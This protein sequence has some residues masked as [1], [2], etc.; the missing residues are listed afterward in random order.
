MLNFNFQ[1]TDFNLDS[2]SA[3][4]KGRFY[5]IFQLLE[6]VWQNSRMQIEST[7]NIKKLSTIHP[8]IHG[9]GYHTVEHTVS[10]VN[11][12]YKLGIKLHQLYPLEYPAIDIL[13]LLIGAMLHDYVQ[14]GDINLVSKK[15]QIKE[16]GELKIKTTKIPIFKRETGNNEFSSANIGVE[17]MKSYNQQLGKIIFK[18]ENINSLLNLIQSTEPD[19]GRVVVLEGEKLI[20][21]STVVQPK[22]ISPIIITRWVICVSDLGTVS[23]SPDKL[24]E[25]AYKLIREETWESNLIRILNGQLDPKITHLDY[26]ETC[27]ISSL[28]S[29]FVNFQ[30]SFVKAQKQRTKNYLDMFDSS[31]RAIL[32]PFFQEHDPKVEF[33][34]FDYALALVETEVNIVNQLHQEILNG[35]YESFLKLLTRT[36]YI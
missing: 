28:I 33:S 36:Q 20:E 12:C 26:V 5:K 11:Y 27:V 7:S 8:T 1:I 6:E 21:Y 10:V 29:E 30:S 22:L 15:Y 17:L 9:R 31:A 18:P 19:F 24:I 13:I 14:E 32:I 3:E 25:D 2:V 23:F 16:N 4:E 35:N 34:N